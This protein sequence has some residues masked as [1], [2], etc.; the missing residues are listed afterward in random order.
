MSSSFFNG[1]LDSDYYHSASGFLNKSLIKVM[2]EANDDIALWQC[3]V[4]RANGDNAA[5]E[6][7]VSSVYEVS[8]TASD[9]KGELL[10]LIDDCGQNF[11][12]AMDSDYDFVACGHNERSTLIN[13]HKFV[14][15]SYCYALE[16]FCSVPSL[17]ETM[18]TQGS[19]KGPLPDEVRFSD[20]MAT[21]EKL[22]YPLLQL[23]VYSKKCALLSDV[24]QRLT[25]LYR[26]ISFTGF[27]GKFD[28][29]FAA[30]ASYVESQLAEINQL[31][32]V[33]SLQSS[34]EYQA[35][36]AQI[37]AKFDCQWYLMMRGHDLLDKVVK[38]LVKH[39]AKK[40]SGVAFAK[41]SARQS[42]DKAD[43]INQFKNSQMDVQQLVDNNIAFDKAAVFPHIISDIQ[44]FLHTY[45]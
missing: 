32:D 27:D 22:S 45:H 35:W 30:I 9:G 7:E 38:P 3:L 24:N 14:L 36:Q 39:I 16:N 12:V 41:L 21:L 25:Q 34:A 2:V 33:S 43:K 19:K 44:Q 15:Q 4:E 17:I 1:E 13:N 31:F 37:A 20:V 40:R 26:E 18:I 29:K 28:D 6:F 11:L 10:K 23:L 42:Q 5:V 8:D